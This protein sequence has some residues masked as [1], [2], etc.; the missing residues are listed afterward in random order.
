MKLSMPISR[1]IVMASLSVILLMLA[2]LLAHN[3]FAGKSKISL[4]SPVSFPIDI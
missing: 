3:V 1:R 4:N 2:A